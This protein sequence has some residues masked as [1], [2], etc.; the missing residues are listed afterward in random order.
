MG[1]MALEDNRD[2]GETSTKMKVKR[3]CGKARKRVAEKSESESESER[4]AGGRESEREGERGEGCEKIGK[5]GNWKSGDQRPFGCI[6]CL[7]WQM[8]RREFPWST[9]IQEKAGAL[10]LEL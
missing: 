5:S 10:S 2:G 8:I 9:R 4:G 7:L 6:L 3:K 1:D